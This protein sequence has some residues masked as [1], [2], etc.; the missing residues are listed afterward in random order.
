[1]RAPLVG[2]LLA[3]LSGGLG[4]CAHTTEPMEVDGAW[5][6]EPGARFFL[7]GEQTT[8]LVLPPSLL[9]CVLGSIRGGL[10]EAGHVVRLGYATVDDAK[11]AAQQ[12]SCDDQCVIVHV[13]VTA[14]PNGGSRVAR[15]LFTG[16]GD[17]QVTLDAT[18]LDLRGDKLAEGHL[19]AGPYE[20][21]ATT[22]VLV[23]VVPT[24]GPAFAEGVLDE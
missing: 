8:Q 2:L 10:G 13:R 16:A 11:A 7:V 23:H 1:M 17:M 15:A 9:A 4:A 12:A 20:S 19:V 14:F 3:L 24:I 21:E 22:Q 18:F 6:A 5:R